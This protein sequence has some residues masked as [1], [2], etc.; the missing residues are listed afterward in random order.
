MA[1]PDVRVPRRVPRP[2]RGESG[3]RQSAAFAVA[4]AAP[5]RLAVEQLSPEATVSSSGISP[6]PVELLSRPARLGASTP[7]GVPPAARAGSSFEPGSITRADA[8]SVLAAPAR[9]AHVPSPEPGA[10]A[11]SSSPSPAVVASPAAA[12]ASSTPPGGSTPRK[13]ASL[14]VVDRLTAAPRASDL[15]GHSPPVE[16]LSGLVSWWDAHEATRVPDGAGA[17]PAVT[18][19][20]VTW[21]A[22]DQPPSRAPGTADAALEAAPLVR[23]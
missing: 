21:S 22:A 23:L 12:V 20:A 2:P 13:E 18:G 10:T 8:A 19:H 5:R 7:V 6:G 9:A 17:T 1:M 14:A 4:S 11:G 3:F 16:G 15:G